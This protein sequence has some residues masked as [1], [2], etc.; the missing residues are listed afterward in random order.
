M[1]AP[2]EVG[3][4]RVFLVL[5]LTFAI[6]A[7]ARS[8][9]QLITRAAHAPLAFTLSAL[10]AVIYT[11]GLVL[12]ARW[13]HGAARR[14]MWILCWVELSG[15]IVVGSLSL[16][17]PDLFPEATVWSAFGRGY[18]FIPAVLPVVVM[19]W[20][21]RSALATRAYTELA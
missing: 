7:G 13:G 11:V 5:Y 19:L 10:A 9:V 3:P 12:L 20:L 17:R 16:A 21:R 1:T 4:S 2:P 15:V 6:G 8:A 18:L 14:A